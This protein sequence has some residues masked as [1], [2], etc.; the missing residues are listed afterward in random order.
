[1]DRSTSASSSPRATNIAHPRRQ[2]LVAIWTV[3]M[4]A[5]SARSSMESGLQTFDDTFFKKLT[6]YELTPGD[7]IGDR[8]E[9]ASLVGNGGMG[10]VYV[11]VNTAIGLQVA[12]KLLKP[13]FLA[14]P[15]FRR[16]FQQ[17]AEAVAAIE[18]PN[19]VR[20]FDLVIGDPTFIVMEYVRGLTLAQVLDRERRLDV[21]RAVSIAIRLCWG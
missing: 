7:V 10:R 3:G 2:R 20:F 6:R 8:Y 21:K 1:M 5:S 18:H 16:R 19:V 11:A 4:A 15:E 9:I 13:E 12:V 17:E 14:N